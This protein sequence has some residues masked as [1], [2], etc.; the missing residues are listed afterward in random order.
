MPDAEVKNIGKIEIDGNLPPQSIGKLATSLYYVHEETPIEVL[1]NIF[2]DETI[3]I[4]AVG[5]VDDNMYGKGT[6]VRKELASLLSKPFGREVL[7]KR[8]V[9]KV[10]SPT[11]G[12]LS[13]QHIFIVSDEVDREV[14]SGDEHYFLLLDK[15]GKFSGL[16]STQDILIYLSNLTQK[17]I[18]MAHNLQTRMVKERLAVLTADLEIVGSSHTAKG[19]GG[20]YYSAKKI[21]S[22]RWILSL[23]D[24]SG[25][26][27][28]ASIVTAM[29]YGIQ[30]SYDFRYGLAEFVRK[31]NHSIFS[32]FNAEKYLTGIFMLFDEETARLKVLDMGH[33]FISLIRDGRLHTI[34]TSSDNLPVGITAH[35]D[36]QVGALTLQRK[37]III[38]VTDG[39]S[40]QKN[41]QGVE[42]SMKRM[43]NIVL[44]RCEDSLEEI[45]E[46]IVE[47]FHTFKEDA[48]YH[49]DVTFMLI[50]YPDEEEFNEDFEW[51]KNES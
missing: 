18:S 35:I 49:D 33:S 41:N 21:S 26:G 51:D 45:R 39:L 2:Q 10:I 5:V 36:P 32:T 42:Y 9:R 47:D 7:R 25:K 31:L 37:D 3:H 28:A 46:H 29:L 44:S 4:P 40:E 13:S 50:R 34:T 8:P 22:T 11:R 27:V 12:F 30:E 19:V 38:V 48:P 17:D 14:K 43:H 6:I 1:F 16:F 15:E 20:D 23:C 24:V